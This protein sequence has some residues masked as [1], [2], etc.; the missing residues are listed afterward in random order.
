[1]GLA[2]RRVAGGVSY[3]YVAGGLRAGL[4]SWRVAG[5]AS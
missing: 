3:M 1:M 4:A 5:G 2:S